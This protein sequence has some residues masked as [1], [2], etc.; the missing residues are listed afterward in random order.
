MKRSVRYHAARIAVDNGS[1]QL[2]LDLEPDTLSAARAAVDDVNSG[3]KLFA[4]QLAEYRKPR[5]LDANAYCWALIDQLAE[6]LHRNKTEID[7][8]AIRGIG[9]VS[10]TVCV[11]RQ[12]AE[13]LCRT[14]T[15][16]DG[17]FTE[18][19]ES[20]L[21][22]CVNVTLYYGSS[23]YDTAQMSALIDH[24][25]QDAAALGIETRTPIE[26]A[27]LMDDWRQNETSPDKS[28]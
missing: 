26:L 16:G 24:I 18:T 2:V 22:G 15:H 3:K 6:A 5:S 23:S 8:E 12:A 7:R 13:T 19:L 20:K 27:A 9:G 25:V 1:W 4:A 10:D 21:P 17:W 28:V 11:K 14:W